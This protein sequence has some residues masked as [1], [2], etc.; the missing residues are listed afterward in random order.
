MELK[1]SEYFKQSLHSV[2]ASF[3]EWELSF[4][5]TREMN[6]KIEVQEVSVAVGITGDL[7]GYVYLSVNQEMSKHIT[8]QLLGGME[9]PEL[10]ELVMS[11]IG[12]LGNM[13]MGNACASISCE[14]Y[15]IDITPPSIIMGKEIVISSDVK[16]FLIPVV[17]PNIGDIQLDVAVKAA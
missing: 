5:E 4:H 8:S 11:A 9:V 1:H 12:E 6:N 7:L 17:I 16:I 13:I 10:D 2:F 14:G 3:S 15:H